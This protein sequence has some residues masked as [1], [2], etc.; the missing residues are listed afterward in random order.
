[1]ESST[2][3]KILVAESGNKRK[4]ITPED[5]AQCVKDIAGWYETK[6]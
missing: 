4:T 2:A 6:A 3:S 5:V 1:M